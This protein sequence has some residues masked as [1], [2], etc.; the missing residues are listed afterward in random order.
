MAEQNILIHEFT[1]SPTFLRNKNSITIL[2]GSTTDSLTVGVVGSGKRV[3]LSSGQTLT[4]NASTGFTL[5]NIEILGTNLSAQVV[6][7]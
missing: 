6:T 3:T 7:S 4:L 5:P 2:N 1:T